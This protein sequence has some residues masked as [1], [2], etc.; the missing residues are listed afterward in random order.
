MGEKTS[1]VKGVAAALADAKKQA[2]KQAK[3]AT[4]KKA[5]AKKRASKAKKKAAPK[6]AP[7][8]KGAP[9][10]GQSATPIELSVEGLNSKEAKVVEA[11]NGAGTGMRPVLT[12]VEIAEM[13]FKSQ[14]KKKSNSW[15]RNSL[16]RLVVSGIVE[17][18]ER[19][20]YRISEAGRKKLARAA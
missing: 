5:P 12:I 11:L 19:G 20:T 3:K 1:K 17:K 10:S 8:K 14:G 13:C 6:K 16:R 18:V 2:K 9:K 7:A 15:A 4:P